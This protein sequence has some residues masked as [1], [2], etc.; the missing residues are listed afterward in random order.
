MLATADCMKKV[1]LSLLTFSAFFLT[2]VLLTSQTQAQATNTV[3]NASVETADPVN[4]TRPDNWITNTW[5]TNTVAF[6]Y[7]SGGHT[8]SRAIKTDVT[9][10]TS[11]DAKWYYTPQAVTGNQTLR[12]QDWY[13][14]SVES[15]V[16]IWFVM[17]DGSNQYV[18]LAA[19]PASVT[20]WATY[21]QQVTTPANAKKMTVF[22]L[23]S[24]VGWL[25]TD[26]YSVVPVSASPTPSVSPSPSPVVVS[27]TPSPIASPTPSPIPSP[28]PSPVVSPTPSPVPS[29]TGKNIVPNPSVENGTTKPNNWTSEKWGTHTSKFTYLTN[30]AHAG[31]KSVKAE[32]TAYTSGDSKW[33]FNPQAVTA[34]QKYDISQWYQSNVETN[35]VIWFTLTNGSSQ[36]IEITPA[37]A[38]ATWAHYNGQVTVPANAQKMSVFHLIKKVG[39]VVTDNFSVKEA[40]VAPTPTPSPSP[41]VI[42]TP[43]PSPSP[44]PTPTPTPTPSPSPSSSPVVNVVANP[45]FET[46]TTQPTSWTHQSWGTMTKAFTYLTNQAKTGTKSAKVEIT[47]HTDGDAKW[48]FTPVAVTAGDSFSF[49]DWYKSNISSSVVIDFTLSDGTH[50]YQEL[51]T[52][53]P[54]ADWAHYQESFQVPAGATMM[55]VYHLINKV[56]WIITDD[57]SLTK[58][59][60]SSFNRPIVSITFDDGWEDNVITALPL[61]ESLGFHATYYFATSF[62]ENSPVTGP[63]TVSGPAAVQHIYNNGHEIGSHSV[64]HPDMTT[65]TPEQL[66][67]ESSNPKTYLESIIGAGKVKNFATPYGAYNAAVLNALMPVYTSHRPTDEGYNTPANFDPYRLKVQNMLLGTTQT[68]FEGW[69]DQTKQNKSWLILVY[70]NV[71]N[72]DLDPYDT[73]AA[74]FIQQMNYLKN[75][76]VTV[77]TMEQALQEVTGQVQ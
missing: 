75:S 18:E 51:R 3:P 20:D 70:H 49:S 33:Y 9:A 7:V 48:V 77:L 55:T 69:I 65:L 68:Q 66:A 19:A 64:T 38:S 16:V 50:Y 12:V 59:P 37:P 57:Y 34:G 44:S 62:L 54:A 52:A 41:S 8:D 32:I 13:K 10:Y 26:N 15:R 74:N 35:I 58:I 71:T 28:T 24:Q 25:I 30:L 39:W 22:H 27:P 53:A 43:T 73:P 63:I 67:Y 11:G 60:T 2:A 31:N 61:M 14:S 45:S 1:F 72:T 17:Q 23:V 29:P 21:N 36:Y 6:S 56:G 76:G 47:A 4:N 46:G 40:S 5:G 42:P